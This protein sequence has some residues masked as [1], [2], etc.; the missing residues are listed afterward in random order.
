M[1]L[2]Q[3]PTSNVRKSAKELVYDSLREWIID[4]TLAPGEKLV[5]ANIAAYFAV[6]RTPVR[7]A[8]LALS[9]QKLV[10]V[11]PGKATIVSYFDFN[12][13]Y[14]LYTANSCL[15]ADVLA[16]AYPKIDQEYLQKLIA[17]NQ[18][19]LDLNEANNYALFRSLDIEFHQAFF[20]LVDNPYLSEF[21]E[22]LDIHSLRVENLF[23][24]T[25]S[26]IRQSYLGHKKVLQ[27]LEEHDLAGSIEAMKKNFMSTID[28]IVK[29][30]ELL[31]S[32]S[33]AENQ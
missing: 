27:C 7:E 24:K 19:F 33:G 10:E 14:S 13:I 9:N 17:I 3:K 1:P 8:I 20:D 28:E 30:A 32:L 5:D 2:P 15:H 23:F 25:A 12:N 4:G 18:R 21:K 11:L 26:N 16:L 22:T 31:S 6:S 29:N